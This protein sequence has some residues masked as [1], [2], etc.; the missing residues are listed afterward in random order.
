M[1]DSKISALSDGSTP[2]G[3]DAFAVARSGGTTK[4]LT[5]TELLAAMS[6]SEIGYDQI[7]SS[8]NITGT[9]EAS[10]TTIITCG[11]HT[12]DGS[13]VLVTFSTQQLVT[14]TP[15]GAA[16][17]VSLWEGATEITELTQANNA[18]LSTAQMIVPATGMYRFTPSAGTHTYTVQAY[19]T[20]MT[21]TPKIGA[22]SGGTAGI[23]PAF[24]RFTKV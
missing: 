23:A 8:V 15:S 19:T 11:S 2:A 3:S 5:W 24:I 16:V 20:S 9:S 1:A 17:V 14:P 10:S 13:P 7:T 6:G 18:S 12:F 4:K 22:G 21:G